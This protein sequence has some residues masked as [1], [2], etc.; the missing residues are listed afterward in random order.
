[1]NPD[2]VDSIGFTLADKNPG[3]FRL[4]VR[5][6]ES[7]AGE[8]TGIRNPIDNSVESEASPRADA[9]EVIQL[10]IAKGAPLYNAG[11]PEACADIYEVACRAL[12][13]MP[14]LPGSSVDVINTALG[15]I[16]AD[17]DPA[18]RAW[19]LRYALDDVLARLNENDGSREDQ[20]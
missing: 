17:P 13:A 11:L 20:V 9:I 19:I 7:L 18:S 14:E 1:M 16:E 4:E 15:R 10:A 6:V 12:T 5:S 8:S 3:R 2:R